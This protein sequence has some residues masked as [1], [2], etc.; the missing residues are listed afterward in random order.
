ML[1][2]DGYS[3]ICVEPLD[4]LVVAVLVAGERKLNQYYTLLCH[5]CLVVGCD[6]A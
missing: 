4:P 3:S 2:G 6:Q 1:F 5:L